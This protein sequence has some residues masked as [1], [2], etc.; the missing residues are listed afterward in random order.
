MNDK[1]YFPQMIIRMEISRDKRV[2]FK[3]FM[4]DQNH[5]C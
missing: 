4:S 1:F 3:Q 2:R 5:L